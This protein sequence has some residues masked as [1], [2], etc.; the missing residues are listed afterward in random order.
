MCGQ[1]M[2][3]YNLDRLQKKSDSGQERAS[4]QSG[5]L[6]SARISSPSM[7]KTFEDLNN[8]SIL[9]PTTNP[10]D[11]TLEDAFKKARENF[12]ALTSIKDSC[13]TKSPT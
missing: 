2:S 12:A 7:E 8:T 9:N 5:P 10:G 6:E 3:A 11:Q 4:Y 1:D 13:T